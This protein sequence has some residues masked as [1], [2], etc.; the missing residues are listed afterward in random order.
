M[1]VTVCELPPETSA[2]T[3]AWAALW[4]HTV[5]HASELVLHAE[6]ALVEPIWESQHL[7]AARWSAIE[8]RATCLRRSG[9]EGREHGRREV[10]NT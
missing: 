10:S 9:G 1:R 4:D 8:T 6:L 3:A 7:D 2:L 5:A